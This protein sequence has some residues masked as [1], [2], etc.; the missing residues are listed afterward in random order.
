[1]TGFNELSDCNSVNVVKVNPFF[2]T[3]T[4]RLRKYHAL[5]K[6]LYAHYYYTCKNVLKLQ[7]NDAHSNQI[8]R[9]IERSI[10]P[11]DVTQARKLPLTV[12]FYVLK[13]SVLCRLPLNM[14]KGNSQLNKF[15]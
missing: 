4:N 3:R 15:T 11:N 13:D 6:L 12:H 8:I 9:Y 7:Q 10:L 1:M 14:R 5:H 2:M